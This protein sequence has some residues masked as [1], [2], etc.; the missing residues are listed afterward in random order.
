MAIYGVTYYFRDELGTTVTR[1]LIAEVADEAALIVAAGGM[2]GLL[3]P[4]TKCE[5]VKYAY[6]REVD[7]ADTADAG[8]NV[9]AGMR[10]KWESTLP[11]APVTRIP[12]PIDAIKLPGRVIDTSN[13]NVAAFIAAFT[14]GAWRV[15]STLPTQPTGVLAATVD[16]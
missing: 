10:F 7:V 6:R 16:V 8:S 15:N 13:A 14:G 12:D 11:T 3:G 5:I 1:E 9:D 2:A 4:I